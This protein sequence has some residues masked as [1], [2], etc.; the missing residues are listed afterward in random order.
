M[1][2]YLQ[3]DIHNIIELTTVRPHHCCTRHNKLFHGFHQV[4][5]QVLV[6]T[7]QKA[8]DL[9]SIDE[10]GYKFTTFWVTTYDDVCDWLLSLS[11]NVELLFTNL[12]RL[13]WYMLELDFFV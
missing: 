1:R 8:A 5:M 7:G 9:V 10:K 6:T 11:Y 4:N 12:E 2:S 3:N 13:K